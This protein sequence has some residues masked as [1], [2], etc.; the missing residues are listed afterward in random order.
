MMPK[1]DTFLITTSSLEVVT[2]GFLLSLLED[3]C[4]T[5]L[6]LQGLLAWLIFIILLGG[7]ILWI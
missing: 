4:P 6:P 5:I 1:G 2:A 3:Y 7:E